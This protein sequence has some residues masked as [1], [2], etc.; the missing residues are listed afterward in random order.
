MAP[1]LS[2]YPLVAHLLPLWSG[3]TP[4]IPPVEIRRLQA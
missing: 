1:N 3:A 4:A 2:L